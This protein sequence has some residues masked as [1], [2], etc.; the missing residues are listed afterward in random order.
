ME[1]QVLGSTNLKVSN[2]G[3][4]GIPLQRLDEKEAIDVVKYSFEKGINFIDTA[5]GYS[6]SEKYIGKAIK[7]NRDKLILA[8][9]SPARDYKGM[10]KALNES[11]KNL[12]TDYIG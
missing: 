11:F 12:Q 10:K 8:T 7:D 6:V 5:R 4:G 9:K 2:I 1:K 3:L